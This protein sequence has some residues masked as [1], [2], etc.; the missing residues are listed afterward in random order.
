MEF[1]LIAS[2]DDQR[3]KYD[4]STIWQSTP[5]GVL[6][7]SALNLWTP[8]TA[9]EAANLE[10]RKVVV[11]NRERNVILEKKLGHG[12]YSITVTLQPVAQGHMQDVFPWASNANY[13]VW[14]VGQEKSKLAVGN[15]VDPHAPE[16]TIARLAIQNTFLFKF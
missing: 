8:K 6:R 7:L 4:S 16:A 14:P 5:Y 12:I 1:A 11:E 2:Q 3:S 9:D 15:C 10:G 13:A